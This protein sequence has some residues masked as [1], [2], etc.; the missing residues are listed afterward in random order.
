MKNSINPQ[1]SWLLDLIDTFFLPFLYVRD[2]GHKYA[3]RKI[4]NNT[5]LKLRVNS[6]D[7]ITVWEVWKAGA[8]NRVK[9]K[10]SMNIIDI[11]AHIGSFSIYAA[12]KSPQGKVYAYEPSK[13]NFDILSENAN[14][15]KLNNIK[16]YNLAVS[17]KSGTTNLYI[18]K[19]RALNSL[20][21]NNGRSQKINCTDLF[22][23]LK[24]N[25]LKSVDILKIDAEGSEFDI[26]MTSKFQ[27]LNKIKNIILEYHDKN[28]FQN[29]ITLGRFLIKQGFRVET[30]GSSFQKWLFG[31]GYI[32]ATNLSP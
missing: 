29:S 14:L 26:L 11:G 28:T 16:L 5:I 19:N 1:N 3:I 12:L 22:H 32:L 9:I 31:T 4:G 13:E 30:Y 21:N 8:Y 25:S 27:T 2:W 17:S 23:I 15:N 6:S 10:N 20:I 7:L 18:R 24:Q